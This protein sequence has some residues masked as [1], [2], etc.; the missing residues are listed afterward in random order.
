MAKVVPSV[1]STVVPLSSNKTNRATEPQRPAKTSR[2]DGKDKSTGSMKSANAKAKYTRL[3][4]N[5]GLQI[6]AV[7]DADGLSLDQRA[8]KRRHVIALRKQRNLEVI[9]ALAIEFCPPHVSEQDVDPDWFYSFTEM[10]ENISTK[11]MQELWGKIL[12]GEITQ[13]GTF[14]YKSLQILRKM[15][16]KEAQAFQ[17]AVQLSCRTDQDSGSRIIS[18]FYCKPSLLNIFGMSQRELINLSKYGLSY[19]QLLS[20]MD[21]DLVHHAEI[22][23]GEATPDQP[24]TLVYAGNY[25]PLQPKRPKTVMTYYKLTQSGNE[26]ARLMSV[27]P[28]GSYFDALKQALGKGYHIH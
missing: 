20:L 24:L 10:A 16:L 9:L 6:D 23:S 26:L 14:S 28:S 11:I 13:P 19:P 15:T 12:A 27:T 2:Q 18:G 5:L 21:I 3:F 17:S 4:A 22:E 8:R 1:S 7:E 25:L